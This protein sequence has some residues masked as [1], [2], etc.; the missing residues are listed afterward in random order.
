MNNT[1][2]KRPVISL[3]AILL[4]LST[5]LI[6]FQGHAQKIDSTAKKVAHKTA[7]TAVKGSSAIVDKIYK[8][9]E[10]PNGQTVYINKS[11][12]KYYV[13]NKGKKIYLKSWQIK[14]KKEQ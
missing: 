9:K 3:W 4:G 14:D 8:G 11:D 10:G 7:S 13:D 12:K 2:K 5:S 1:T 6:A